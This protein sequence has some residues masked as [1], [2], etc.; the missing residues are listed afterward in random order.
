MKFKEI[1]LKDIFDFT[2]CVSNGSKFT[3]EIIHNNIGDIPVYG[4][5][6][7]KNKPS[8]GYIKDGV[9]GVKYFENCLTWN[10]DG[11][12]GCFYRAG[13][14]TLSEKVIPL[15]I[16]DKH[17]NHIDNIFLSFVLLRLANEQGF[18]REYK[19]NQAKLKNVFIKI[20][21]KEDGSFDLE[22]QE[23]IAKRYERIENFQNVMKDYLKT[24]KNCVIKVEHRKDIQYKSI[25]L[26]DKNLFSVNIGKRITKEELHNK[27]EGSYP[28]FSANVYSSF[29]WVDN[30]LIKD[31]SNDFV[32]WGIDGTWM[33][34]FI[35][36]NTSFIPTDHCGYLQCFDSNINLNYISYMLK[37]EGNAQGFSRSYRSSIENIK[38]ISIQIPI[39]QDGT[40][41]LEEQQRIAKKYQNIESKRSEAIDMLKRIIDTQVKITME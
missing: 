27:A 15:Y 16:Q 38:N 17:I 23:K 40:Y 14:F 26:K 12:L 34:R 35:P 21:I 22:A 4:A 37:Q 6:Q 29:G 31:F 5:S 13:R 10:I 19:P 7:Y 9:E 36:K 1:E 18:S 11:S 25:D 28:V 3:K 2:R 8:Y 30:L 41:D 33:T 24:I 39:K 32:V 20:P